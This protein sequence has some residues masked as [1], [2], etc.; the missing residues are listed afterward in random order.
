MD[1]AYAKLDRAKAHRD[2]LVRDMKAFDAKDAFDWRF[3]EVPA[4][5][6]RLARFAVTIQNKKATP[7]NWSLIVGDILT[8]LRA[9]LDHALFGHASRRRKLTEDEE[10]WLQFPIVTNRENWF[11]APAVPATSTTHRK[12]KIDSK[13]DKLAPWVDTDVLKAIEKNQ[14]FSNTKISDPKFDTLAVLDSLVNRDKHREVRVVSYVSRDLTVEHSTIK[15][16]KVE[17]F[18]VVMVDGATVAH[19]TFE[20]TLRFPWETSEWTGGMFKV[21]NG[22]NP[23]IKV[24]LTGDYVSVRWAMNQLVREVEE[25]LKALKK[26]GC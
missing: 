14:P 1:S 20:R 11:G 10:R 21:L 19:I 22:Y 13:R 9:A 12:K 7:P 6:P 3:D 25:T 17:P 15:V 5:H 2:Q 8:N 18:E 26:A 24:P 4:P 23:C 16:V